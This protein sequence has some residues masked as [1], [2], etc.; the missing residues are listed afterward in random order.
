V[1]D[2]VTLPP[3]DLP[4]LHPVS[5]MVTQVADLIGRGGDPDA[6]V[7]ALL[8]LNRAANHMN[9]AGVFM[10]RRKEVTF[11]DL[12]AGDST[13]ALPADWGWPD[14]GVRVYNS[15]GKLLTSVEWLDW[16]RF[17]RSIDDKTPSGANQGPPQ[18]ISIRSE[19]DEL[20]HIYPHLSAEVAEIVVPY[21]ARVQ[22]LTDDTELSITPEIE[23]CLI[24][25]GEAFYTRH[26][27]LT[28]PEVWRP[29]W[30][31]FLN[32]IIQAK[33]A[34]WRYRQAVHTNARPDESGAIEDSS[35]LPNYTDTKFWIGG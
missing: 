34:S 27:H 20:L 19:A 1:A 3:E 28:R 7:K 2:F 33:G 12:T 11:D 21:M 17:Q 32:S 10:S 35:N 13:L 25:G 15:T 31:D 23:E 24:M 5:T 8:Y 26:R 6:E 30:K 18:W 14:D 16:E 22:K 4:V 9:L 29:L